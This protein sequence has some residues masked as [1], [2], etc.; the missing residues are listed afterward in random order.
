[1]QKRPSQRI[2]TPNEAVAVT[3]DGSET[4]S[5]TVLQVAQLATKNLIALARAVKLIEHLKVLQM[6]NAGRRVIAR[7]PTPLCPAP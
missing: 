7:L 6:P 1:M 5:I 3:L 4:Q 2:L